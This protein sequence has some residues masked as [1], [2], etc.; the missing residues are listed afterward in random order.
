MQRVLNQVGV[1]SRRDCEQMIK[2]GRVSVNGQVVTDLPCFVDP[3]HDRIAVD[4][5]GIARR[6]GKRVYIVA[7]KPARV[8]VTTSDEPGMERTT[9]ADLVQ[10]PGAKRLF[11]AGRLEYDATGLVLLTND[12]ELVQRLTHPR[13][14][15]EK[16]YHVVV[17]GGPIG[18]TEL[19]SLQAKVRRQ[20]RQ[21]AKRVRLEEQ[22]AKRAKASPGPM[23]G[24]RKRPLGE[25]P[26]LGVV[27]HDQ[28]RVVLSAT[29]ID[30]R[31]MPVREVLLACGLN[32]RRVTRVGIGPLILK[33]LGMGNWRELTREE[34][35]ALRKYVSDKAVALRQQEH[36]R[37]VAQRKARGPGPMAGPSP[38]PL[39]GEPTDE[40]PE[41]WGDDD[42]Q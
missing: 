16:T 27:R 34:L 42:E 32:V 18:P 36:E 2:E 5:V 29:M 30:A 13:Y 19:A 24:R 14:R 41:S 22:K 21:V 40:Q 15:V 17:Q 4:G 31:T 26:V 12:G 25:P 3:K 38:A 10:H 33:G 39:A 8:L 11:P 7:H 9:L 23:E 35:S 28:G 6:A 1:A 20:A 37:A